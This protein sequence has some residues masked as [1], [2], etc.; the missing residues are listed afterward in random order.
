MLGSVDMS[1]GNVRSMGVAVFF[2]AIHLQRSSFELRLIFAYC[3]H[4][5]I[6]GSSSLRSPVATCCEAV[7]YVVSA[8]RC[9][10]A[11][12]SSAFTILQFKNCNLGT[13]NFVMVYTFRHVVE[14]NRFI[15]VYPHLCWCCASLTR[16]GPCM[17]MQV[18]TSVPLLRNGCNHHR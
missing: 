13:V 8:H 14:I 9:R 17:W 2:S 10:C 12:S 6:T 16:V 4:E 15:C 1:M 5:H 11:A 3:P 7:K 18:L